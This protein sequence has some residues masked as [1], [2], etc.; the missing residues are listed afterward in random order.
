MDE[1][2]GYFIMRYASVGRQTRG[3]KLEV[4]LTASLPRVISEM[5]PKEK[6]RGKWTTTYG[7]SGESLCKVTDSRTVASSKKS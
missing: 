2:C 3:H 4:P 6:G 7:V 1:K 5:A